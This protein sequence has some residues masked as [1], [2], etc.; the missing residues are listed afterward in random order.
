MIPCL[1]IYGVFVIICLVILGMQA[2]Y[3]MDEMESLEAI[4]LCLGMLILAPLIVIVVVFRMI[5]A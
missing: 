2:Q 4:C 3:I 5:R 1:I